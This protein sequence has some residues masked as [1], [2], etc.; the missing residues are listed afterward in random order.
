M[1]PNDCLIILYEQPPSKGLLEAFIA[2]KKK[3]TQN[4][5]QKGLS[6]RSNIIAPSQGNVD[7]IFFKVALT[8]GPFIILDSH[9][10][11]ELQVTISL[12]L[13]NLWLQALICKTV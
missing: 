2:G 9:C 4:K 13:K 10:P 11:K 8:A 12:V 7:I 1:T 5:T 6:L 3:K